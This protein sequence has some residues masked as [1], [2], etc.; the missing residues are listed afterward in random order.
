MPSQGILE[1]SCVAS[2]INKRVAVCI[3]LPADLI[4][5]IQA[6]KALGAEETEAVLLESGIKD[7]DDGRYS[8]IGIDPNGSFRSKGTKCEINGVCVEGAPL[9]RLRRFLDDESCLLPKGVPNML[10]RAIGYIAY[11]TVRLFEKIPHQ[12][13]TGSDDL[14]FQV[15]RTGLYF[16]HLEGR[17]YLA[18]QINVGDC[19]DDDY[20][21]A[22]EKLE[23]LVEK[24]STPVHFV[25]EKSSSKGEIIEE[26]SDLEFCHCVEEAKKYL[27]KGDAFQIVLS[28]SFKKQSAANPLDIYRALRLL[29]PSPFHFFI[30]TGSEVLLGASPERLVKVHEGLVETN[31][32]AGSRPKKT[33][34]NPLK[35][36]EE[37]LEDPKELAEH[38]MLVDLARNDLGSVSIPG[39]VRV[40]NYREVKHFSHV[41]HIVSTVKGKLKADCDALDALR[42]TFPAGTLSGAPKVRAMEL[43]DQIEKS[44]R[45]V[46]GG[47]I[48][49][50]DHRGN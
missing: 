44:A 14:F 32:M 42:G 9:D 8:F 33:E 6:F 46:Y 27:E 1:K 24:L 34:D 43:I 40:S 28:R 22:K 20:A 29:N 18:T 38:A 31:P 11:D 2:R 30:N 15:Y 13:E 50:L 49:A 16:D 36:Q 25:S 5:P 7:S 41:M 26:L 4:T 47:A 21:T 12:H 3:E 23:S 39:S 35:V 48:C 37:L 17:I 45:G 19:P 10:G